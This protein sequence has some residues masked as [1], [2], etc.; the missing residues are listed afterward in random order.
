MMKA[1][2]SIN[3]KLQSKDCNSALRGG[4]PPRRKFFAFKVLKAIWHKPAAPIIA[5]AL[6]VA[7]I[8]WLPGPNAKSGAQALEAVKEAAGKA[9]TA[10]QAATAI[11]GKAIAARPKAKMAAEAVKIATETRVA[12]AISLDGLP[13]AAAEFEAMKNL[14][15]ALHAQLEL[16]IQRGNAWKEAALAQQELV[17]ALQEQQGA[18]IKAGRRKGLAWGAAGGATAVILLVAL[19]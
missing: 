6:L 18:L 4:Q 17:A 12:S 11:E 14:I 19:L 7:A 1:A 2:S 16:E 5:A 8:V 10:T 15:D 13:E 9:E 3:T